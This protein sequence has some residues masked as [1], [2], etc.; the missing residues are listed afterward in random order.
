ME[1]GTGSFSNHWTISRKLFQG[2]EKSAEKVPGLGKRFDRITGLPDENPVHPV[3][4]SNFPILG[5]ADRCRSTQIMTPKKSAP[6]SV[7]LRQKHSP[8]ERPRFKPAF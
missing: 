5:T 3:I 6:I 2:S 4:P 1:T 8:L 7:H